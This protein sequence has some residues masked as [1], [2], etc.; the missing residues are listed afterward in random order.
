MKTENFFICTFCKNRFDVSN[1]PCLCASS[2]NVVISDLCILKKPVMIDWLFT[3]M[4]QNA[5]VYVCDLYR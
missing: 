5:L 3:Y 2:K 1:K 4:E